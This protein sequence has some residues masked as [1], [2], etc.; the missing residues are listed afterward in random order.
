MHVLDIEDAYKIRSGSGG[1]FSRLVVS[2]VVR[3]RLRKIAFCKIACGQ[4]NGILL[5]FQK[6]IALLTLASIG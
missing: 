2:T 4:H 6:V 1:L 3:M 5:A